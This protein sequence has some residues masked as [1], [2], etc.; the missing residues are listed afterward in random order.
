MPN[1]SFPHPH[2][3]TTYS[4]PSAPNISHLVSPI[5][6]LLSPANESICLPMTHS[7]LVGLDIHVLIICCL[8]SLPHRYT[9]LTLS[10]SIFLAPKGVF[11]SCWSLYPDFSPGMHMRPVRRQAVF[12]ELLHILTVGVL[13]LAVSAACT[14]AWGVYCRVFIGPQGWGWDEAEE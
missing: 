8:L 13:K 1:P 14:T 6:Y 7:Q 9:Q 11:W 3:P 5:F 10:F 2:Y 4:N 12:Q